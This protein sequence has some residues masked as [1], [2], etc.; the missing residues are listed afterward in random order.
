MNVQAIYTLARQLAWNV[1]STEI[2][3]ATLLPH[4]NARYHQ[5]ENGIVADINE[6]FFY[7]EFLADT[8]QDQR[9]YTLPSN[10]K[11]VIELSIK[12]LSTDTEYTK[13]VNT[14]IPNL[15][16]AP[17]YY[18]DA[19]NRFYYIADKSL[20]V[21]P[22]PTEAVTDGLKLYG[23]VNL[24]DL[25]SSGTE[26]DIKIPVEQHT[27]L[28]YA[29][30]ADIYRIRGLLNESTLAENEFSD[31][32]NKMISQLADRKNSPTVAE[33]PYINYLS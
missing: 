22:T 2:P 16:Y 9:E 14:R 26:S 18:D 7:D 17:D 13:I 24:V 3:D 20:F 4:L 1:D 28:A 23:V 21:Y 30:R 25:T 32:Y 10:I 15:D 12:Y 5:I 31:K 33:M 8:V 19:N 11:K 6:D 29:L 27:I